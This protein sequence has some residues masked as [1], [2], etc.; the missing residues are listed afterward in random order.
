MRALNTFSPT[1]IP[2]HLI[3]SLPR[4]DAER[5]YPVFVEFLQKYYE[6][7]GNYNYD[8]ERS[9]EVSVVPEELLKFFKREFSPGFDSGRAVINERKFIELVRGVYK[10]KGSITGI[11]LLF[12]LFFGQAVTVYEPYKQVLKASDGKWYQEKSITVKKTYNAPEVP[13][14][15]GTPLLSM[16]TT[17]GTF[18]VETQRIEI[19]DQETVRFFFRNFTKIF[20]DSNQTVEIFSGDRII[21]RGH[22]T[23]S[24]SKLRIAEPGKYW[25]VGQVFKIPGTVKDTIAR[26][27]AV[28]STGGVTDTEI[29]EFGDAHTP[30]QIVRISPFPNA[31][32]AGTVT[33]ES[34]IIGYDSILG[35]YIYEHIGTIDDSVFEITEKVLGYETQDELN[36]YDSEFYFLEDYVAD[37]V[38]NKNETF[39]SSQQIGAQNPDLTLEMWLESRATFFYEFGNITNY[40]GK[41]TNE[42]GQLSN[43]WIKLQDSYFYQLFSYVIQ[44]QKQVGEYREL[45]EQ[46][47]AAG[48]KYF[49]ELQRDRIFSITPSAI[50]SISD[51][52]I[53]IDESA[54]IDDLDPLFDVERY[55]ESVIY[56]D[57]D[58]LIF[59]PGK[60]FDEETFADDV[61]GDVYESEGYFS[62]D[63]TVSKL[64]SPY[65]LMDKGEITDEIF[66]NENVEK[67]N[68][69]IAE[70]S[71]SA[72]ENIESKVVYSV[73]Q[74]SVSSLDS[75]ITFSLDSTAS[76]DSTTSETQLLVSGIELT[77]SISNTDSEIVSSVSNFFQDETTN[78]ETT[79]NVVGFTATT[80]TST[81]SDSDISS[82]VYTSS[83]DTNTASDDALI[84][85]TEI[86]DDSVSVTESIQITL[87]SVA[88]T[89]SVTSDDS[90]SNDSINSVATPDSATAVDGTPAEPIVDGYAT[91]FFAEDYTTLDL[92]LTIG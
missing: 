74:D 53:G 27:T 83:E 82:D 38:I 92:T 76:D 56:A 6:F 60:G 17:K 68:S 15:T 20:V 89:D 8:I 16:K 5:D 51:N 7:L 81:P 12:R 50:G 11:E 73:Q 19:L 3:G 32:V 33:F 67:S 85:L 13:T 62:E 26:V 21:F 84:E 80:D 18:L 65:I 47:H 71:N 52:K 88:T 22:I 28:N 37:E 59:E 36:K 42:D 57:E 91:V 41:Y 70:D 75:D 4:S 87:Q 69:V 64:I 72:S 79:T 86:Y 9:R 66:S 25:R 54:D 31:P 39:G 55:S 63:Y 35:E 24:P 77:D 78:T 10:R 14:L 49:A 58:P 34:T 23:E 46:I 44:S 48:T 61:S 43:P 30:G 90:V 2:Q 1:Q 29:I 45:I 40:K